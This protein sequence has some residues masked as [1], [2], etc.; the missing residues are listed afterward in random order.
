MYLCVMKD[1]LFGSSMPKY[2]RISTKTGERTAGGDYGYA[3]VWVPYSTASDARLTASSP[4]SCFGR[5]LVPVS[6]DENVTI[7]FSRTSKT[8]IFC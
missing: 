6:D 1:V 7:S 8:R 5:Y 3:I 4:I 2:W